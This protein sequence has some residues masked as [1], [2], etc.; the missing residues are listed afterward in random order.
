V[1]NWDRVLKSGGKPNGDYA[2]HFKGWIE[3]LLH[4]VWFEKCQYV[5]NRIKGGFMM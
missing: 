5:I 2:T 4:K 1:V 3:K